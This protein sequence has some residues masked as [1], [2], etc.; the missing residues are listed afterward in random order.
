MTLHQNLQVY[1]QICPMCNGTGTLV[2]L[3][4]LVLQLS[5]VHGLLHQ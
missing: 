3:Y 5:F 1:L 2:S 4:F